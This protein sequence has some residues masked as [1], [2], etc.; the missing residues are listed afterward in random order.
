MVHSDH[1]HDLLSQDQLFVANRNTRH[2][3]D[4]WKEYA[5]FLH[6]NTRLGPAAIFKSL[7]KECRTKQKPVQFLKEDIVALCGTKDT[8]GS[9]LDC[10]NLISFLKERQEHDKLLHWNYKSN[11][12]GELD[13]AFF[14]MIGGHDAWLANGGKVA[15]LDT[16]HGTNRYAFYLAL[17]T[18]V[19]SDGKTCVLAGGLLQK[20]DEASFCWLFSEFEKAFGGRPVTFFTDGDR[21]M[22]PAIAQIWPDTIHLLCTFHLFK[23][24][25]HHM[26]SGMKGEDYKQALNMWWKVAKGTDLSQRDTF[27]NR[28]TDLCNFIES[29]HDMKKSYEDKKRWLDGMGRKKEMWA[30]CYTWQHTTLGVHST[31]RAEAINSSVAA[32][33]SKHSNVVDL[34]KDLEAMALDQAMASFYTRTRNEAQAGLPAHFR[35]RPSVEAWALRLSDFARK[36]V[37]AQVNLAMNYNIEKKDEDQYAIVYSGRVEDLDGYAQDHGAQEVVQKRITSLEGCSC[38]FTSCWK[39]PCRHQFRLLLDLSGNEMTDEEILSKF[40]VDDLWLG[41]TEADIQEELDNMRKIKIR[42]AITTTQLPPRTKAEREAHLTPL[43]R[44]AMDVAKERESFTRDLSNFL[45]DFLTRTAAFA[46]PAT[47]A[48]PSD[49][50]TA[51]AKASANASANASDNVSDKASVSVANPLKKRQQQKRKQPKGSVPTTA[52]YKKRGKYNTR[53]RGANM[54]IAS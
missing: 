40:P 37:L 4:D 21:A 49:T 26:K 7:Q 41:R 24:F 51:S 5:L 25:S 43:V 13:R 19:K 20:Q 27:E 10:S 39:L 2:I 47:T 17:F 16:K 42:K 11:S 32:F 38:Q 36:L 35:T 8:F 9:S 54:H 12:E 18:T 44:V 6:R 22:A 31:Q 1:N 28:W 29:K 30:A 14:T 48:T 15:I 23:N 50:A 3:P 52:A 46:T 34:L 33:C 53:K 45:Q